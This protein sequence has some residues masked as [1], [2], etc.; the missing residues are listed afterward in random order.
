MKNL[1]RNFGNHPISACSLIFGLKFRR[2]DFKIKR[3]NIHNRLLSTLYAIKMS[4]YN[5]K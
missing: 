4:H 2:K 5:L 1:S 3:T